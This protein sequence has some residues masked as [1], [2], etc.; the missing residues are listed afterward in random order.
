MNALGRFAELTCH[1]FGVTPERLEQIRS[2][3]IARNRRSGASGA[4]QNIIET[5]LKYGWP[6]G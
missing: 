4:P 5:R 6:V 1:L 2:R 3:S